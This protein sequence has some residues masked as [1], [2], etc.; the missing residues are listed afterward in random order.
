MTMF[1]QKE[2]PQERRGSRRAEESGQTGRAIWPRI[3]YTIDDYRP[4]ARLPHTLPIFAR[5]IRH[6]VVKSLIKGIDEVAYELIIKR[7]L[8]EEEEPSNSE[9]ILP[10]LPGNV[11]TPLTTMPW[12]DGMSR[13][14]LLPTT[15]TLPTTSRYYV[16]VIEDMWS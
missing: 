3:F 2:S 9:M 1:P 16:V 5:V 10:I 14:G 4:E 8:T 13:R 11:T 6:S 12:R 15:S 7:E